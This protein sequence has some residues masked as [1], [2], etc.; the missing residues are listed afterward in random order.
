MPVRLNAWRD[1][2]PAIRRHYRDDLPVRVDLMVWADDVE[3]AHIATLTAIV[4]HKGRVTGGDV[5]GAHD[6][7]FEPP[8]FGHPDIPLPALIAQAIKACSEDIFCV[9][10]HI[11]DAEYVL[12]AATFR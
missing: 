1:T 3:D 5:T 9:I 8:N 7:T 12:D 6:V 11:D 2:A 10:L 4:D